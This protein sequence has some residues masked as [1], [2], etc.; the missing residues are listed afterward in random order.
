MKNIGFII[1]ARLGST[2]LPQ[3]ILL[4]FYNEDSILD[5][6]IKKLHQVSPNIILATSLSREND[7]LEDVAIKYNIACYRGSETDVL[8]RFIEAASKNK[9]DY[10]FRVCSDN[11]FL[12]LESIKKLVHEVQNSEA[13]YDYVSFR[14]NNTPS[15][16][17]HYG[18]WIEF[19]KLSALE[20]VFELTD[21]ELYHEHVTNYIYVHPELFKIHWID[22]PSIIGN[23]PNIRLTI[24]TLDDFN[25]VKSIY[26][27]LCSYNP[28]PCI[29]EIIS[30]LDHFSDYYTLMSKQ[31]K[32]N[33]K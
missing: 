22:T 31:I 5:L 18:F 6:L 14:V 9:I 3:K 32:N 13:E 16:K 4:P 17:T 19:V 27:S 24:D 21:E 12:E 15:I 28:Y 7:Q 33:S 2:R 30:F 10:I 25:N 26:T 8:Q 11:P 1:Q 20:K 23:R 29:E